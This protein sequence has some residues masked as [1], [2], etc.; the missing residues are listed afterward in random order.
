MRWY[1][2]LT[3][4]VCLIPTFGQLEFNSG[5][6]E[7]LDIINL[8]SANSKDLEF[9]P[10]P[11]NGG[12]LY[13]T[14]VKNNRRKNANYFQLTYSTDQED[15]PT[16]LD[17]LFDVV[18]SSSEHIGPITFDH[19]Q[20][21]IFYT[22][23][24]KFRK[25]GKKAVNRIY[26][27]NKLDTV[28]SEPIPFDLNLDDYNVQHPAL[29][30]L[31][32]IIVFSSNMEGGFGGYDLYWSEKKNDQWSAPIN[33]GAGINSAGNEVFPYLHGK[34]ILI[35]SSDGR[36]G[37]GDLDLFIG[38]QS[39]SIWQNAYHLGR[40][41]NSPRDDLG[42]V[43]NPEM[44]AGYFSSNRKGGKGKDDIYKVN[45][46][47]ELVIAKEIAQSD[48]VE[49]YTILATVEDQFGEVVPE[50]RLQLIPFLQE[51]SEAILTN[52]RLESIDVVDGENRFLMNVVPRDSSE[53]IYLGTTDGI[54]QVQFGVA[55]NLSYLLRLSRPG[56][57]S[58]TTAIDASSNTTEITVRLK[59]NPLPTIDSIQSRPEEVDDIPAEEVFE[60]QEVLIFDQIY[61]AFNSSIIS[62]ES[63][64]ELDKLA[65]FLKS[66][67]EK[68]VE[69]NAYTDS[70]G[71]RDYNIQLSNRRANAA[72]EYLI[73]KG[74]EVERIVAK[75]KGEENIRNH[76]TNGV[77]CTEVEHEYNR[78]TE[79]RI[80]D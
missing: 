71:Q 24:H 48:P 35:F 1:F 3:L 50:V 21:T 19:N 9:S 40:N 25:K 45:F 38:I 57:E 14:P 56:Y 75:G 60:K 68:K 55:N 78:R 42:L 20:S 34:Q 51:Q 77:F 18:N 76:C 13:I 46:S 43:I 53:S 69:L 23:T 2:T 64:L 72:K 66:N 79:V 26:Y 7:G 73:G 58:L 5:A 65:N 41:I 16:S 6:L 31:G 59:K 63:N 62:I 61:Y 22:K 44:T 80:I 12:I 39:D 15:R 30:P 33:F 28:W 74:V 4:S 37:L 70:R 11:Y 32:D 47:D 27:S 54:G 17:P 67:P 8:E 49:Y 36:G 52:F 29:S 10:Y